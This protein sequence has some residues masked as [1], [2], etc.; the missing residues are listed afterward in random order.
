MNENEE[1]EHGCGVSGCEG[2]SG[3]GSD[4]DF[5]DID[6]V[7]TLTDENGVDIKFE[8]V[9]V[10]VLDDEKQY[11][12]VSEVGQEENEEQEVVILEIKEEDGEEV[13]D[14][15]TDKDIAE[16]VFNAFEEQQKLLETDDNE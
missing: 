12:I 10:V 5:A 15:V 7:I 9:D 1:L 3:C 14:T 2:C 16:K 6:P 4:T 13:Y 11:L 8:I